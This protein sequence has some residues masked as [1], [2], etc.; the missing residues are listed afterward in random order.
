MFQAVAVPVDCEGGVKDGARPVAAD[1]HQR[2][3]RVR[4]TRPGLARYAMHKVMD[5]DALALARVSLCV[6]PS[7]VCGVAAPEPSAGA[8]TPEMRRASNRQ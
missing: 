4:H 8:A 7:T 1:K 5:L 3:R 6:R 2:F